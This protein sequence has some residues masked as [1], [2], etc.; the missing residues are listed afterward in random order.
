MDIPYRP[1]GLLRELIESMG[2]QITHVFEDL[3]FIEHNAFLLQMGEEGADVR[4]WFNSESLPAE[5]PAIAA[6]LA[7]A[8]ADCGLRVERRGTFRLEQQVGAEQLC[9]ELL[10]GV[11]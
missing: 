2:L 1:L 11:L 6:T 3:I 9:L 10:D 4:L 7:K 8:G 5:R